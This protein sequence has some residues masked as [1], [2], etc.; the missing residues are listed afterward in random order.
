MPS[1]PYCDTHHFWYPKS[2]ASYSQCWK[3][4]YWLSSISDRDSCPGHIFIIKPLPTVKT[5]E[6]FW[7]DWAK[8]PQETCWFQPPGQS[9]CPDL[10]FILLNTFID[11]LPSPNMCKGR[12]HSFAHRTSQALGT[13]V[14]W[15]LKNK[16]IFRVHL[17]SA[18][19]S[20][21][22]FRRASNDK[23]WPLSA[24]MWENHKKEEIALDTN[25]KAYRSFKEE[26]VPLS[27]L[28]RDDATWDHRCSVWKGTKIEKGE[29]TCTMRMRKP[30]LGPSSAEFE[31]Q[32][33]PS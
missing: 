2:P 23:S 16:K 14:W 4:G 15:R 30:E 24:H 32:A 10:L 7:G 33:C 28:S 31:F 13:E 29:I 3:Q 20:A 22:R 18:R 17:L 11:L 8:L 26:Q 27:W 5:A 1:N 6:H 25:D 21:R 9:R 19:N 12:A